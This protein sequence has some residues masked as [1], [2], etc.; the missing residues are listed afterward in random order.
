MGRNLE[1]KARI[2]KVD[3]WLREQLR[4]GPRPICQ[5]TKLLDRDP[6]VRRM[7]EQDN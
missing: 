7:A 3:A 5:A 1:I 4:A 6:I 2:D